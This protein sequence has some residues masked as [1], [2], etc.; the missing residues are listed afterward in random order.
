MKKYTLKILGV[1]A[2]VLVL[3]VMMF[4]YKSAAG[5]TDSTQKNITISV[6]DENSEKE[7]IELETNAETLQEAM[8]DTKMDYQT[9]DGMVMI[10]NGTRAD[11]V[12]DGAYWCFYVNGT[13]CNFG[14]A[15]QPVSDGDNFEIVYTKA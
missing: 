11:Y 5:K 12:L 6:I 15:D 1:F 9:D 10:I 7:I 8:D 14:I 3:T 2:F 13:M 4:V